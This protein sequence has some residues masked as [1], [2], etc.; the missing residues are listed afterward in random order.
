MPSLDRRTLLLGLA[1]LLLL[2]AAVS[3]IRGRE[4]AARPPTPIP[5]AATTADGVGGVAPAPSEPLVVYVTGAVRRPGVYQLRDGQR[6]V[7]A[8]ERAGGVTAKADAVTVNLAAL[9]ID[10]Q[11]ILIPEAYA[12]GAGAAPTGAGPVASGPVHLN[13]ADVTA[14]DALPGIGPATAQR[15]VDWRT[16]HG[17]F[18]TV[19]D[20]EQVPGIGPAKLDALRDLV[21]P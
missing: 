10:G 16:E 14:L 9:L 11:Q 20:L 6:V 15:I 18:R 13:S 21:A 7:D 1:A 3:F 5:V 8:I 19:D 4:G 2:A 12:P 17:G